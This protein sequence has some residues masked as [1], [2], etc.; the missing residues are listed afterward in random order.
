MPGRHQ[1]ASES[2]EPLSASGPACALTR[3]PHVDD[4]RVVRPNVVDL[5]AQLREHARE[6]VREEHVG[7]RDE[8]GE[9]LETFVGA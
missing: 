8:L 5:D 1:N 3:A 4:L 6:L 2:Y 9:D 7:G